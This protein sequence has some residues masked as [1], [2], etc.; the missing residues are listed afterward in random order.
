MA[1]RK[2][3]R[4]QARQAMGRAEAQAVQES[5]L[6]QAQRDFF[7]HLLRELYAGLQDLE[8]CAKRQDRAGKNEEL[9]QKSG[10]LRGTVAYAE[11]LLRLEDGKGQPAEAAVPAELLSL[12]NIAVNNMRREFLYAGVTAHRPVGSELLLQVPREAF[13]FL[14]EEMI[15]CCLRCSPRGKNLHFDLKLVQQSRLLILRTEGAALQQTPLL[16][17]LGQ[18][19]EGGAPEDYGFSMCELLA[20]RLHL[21]FRWEAD[22]AG[23]RMFLTM[24]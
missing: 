17:L 11:A 8:Q 22:E 24:N 20:R 21:R 6:P 7:D 23:V 9:L 16:P 13:L 19:E 15:G 5:T 4:K 18:Q 1:F 14:L 12:I 2:R 10:R 3:E